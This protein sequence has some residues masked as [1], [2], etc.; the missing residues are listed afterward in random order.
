MEKVKI[1]KKEDDD[2]MRLIG[3]CE[4][5]NYQSEL[6]KGSLKGLFCGFKLENRIRNLFSQ[7][8]AIRMNIP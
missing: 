2:E 6:F 4:L 1:G 5:S 8:S 7:I 3:F